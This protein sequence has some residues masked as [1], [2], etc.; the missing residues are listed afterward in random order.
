MQGAINTLRLGW[1]QLATGGRTMR[2]GSLSACFIRL[3]PG[4][5]AR[6]YPQLR[7]ACAWDIVLGHSTGSQEPHAFGQGLAKG[8]AQRTFLTRGLRAVPTTGCS[9]SEMGYKNGRMLPTSDPLLGAPSPTPVRPRYARLAVPMGH[10]TLAPTSRK[11]ILSSC[12]YPS[13]M[14]GASR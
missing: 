13:S 2:E 12:V 8:L 4:L 6:R 10:H 7:E 14:R 9:S 11:A 5:L 3:V 1:D